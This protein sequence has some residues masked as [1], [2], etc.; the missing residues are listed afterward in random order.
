MLHSKRKKFPPETVHSKVPI[1]VTREVFDQQTAL[2]FKKQRAAEK[3]ITALHK[4]STLQGFQRLAE[5]KEH[6]QKILDTQYDRVVEES[7]LRR[8]KVNNPGD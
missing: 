5:L 2:V 8:M 6:K 1:F 7:I 3:A 4:P